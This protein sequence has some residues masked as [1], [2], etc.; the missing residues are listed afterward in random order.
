MATSGKEISY[1]AFLCN[2]LL[3][4]LDIKIINR[5]FGRIMDSKEN[6]RSRRAIKYVF[7]LVGKVA[8]YLAERKMRKQHDR[9]DK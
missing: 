8:V 7:K 2:K 6:T 4:K 5:I 3:G 1:G 9:S